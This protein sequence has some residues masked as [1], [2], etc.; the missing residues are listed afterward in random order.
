MGVFGPAVDYVIATRFRAAKMG[1][2][3]NAE[4]AERILPAFGHDRR[5]LPEGGKFIS[6]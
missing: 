6:P 5:D 1:W 4:V 3:I 2:P